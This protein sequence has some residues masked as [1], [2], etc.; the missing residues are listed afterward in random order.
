MPAAS[1]RDLLQSGQVWRNTAP[2]AACWTLANLAGRY[3][4]LAAHGPAARLTIA[5]QLVLEAQLAREPVA[6][7]TALASSFHPSDLAGNGVDLSALVVARVPSAPAQLRATETL[8][9]AGAFGLV[10]VDLASA[11]EHHDVSLAAQTRLV[12]LA[13]HHGTLLLCITGTEAPTPHAFSSLRAEVS[14]QSISGGGFA[15]HLHVVKDKRA[16][17]GWRH[18]QKCLTLLFKPAR[19]GGRP[20]P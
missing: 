11:R 4:E 1:L 8:L 3:V 14:M 16:G 10:V 15:S 18:E 9:R 12:G 13:Q 19:S 17:P 6:W 20:P 7:V 5:A 2:A